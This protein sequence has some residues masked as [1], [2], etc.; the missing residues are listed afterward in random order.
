MKKQVKEYEVIKKHKQYFAVAKR[1]GA[2]KRNRTGIIGH[3]KRTQQPCSHSR[4]ARFFV[5]ADD[6]IC[7]AVEPRF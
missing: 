4:R 2:K 1:V 7:Y 3:K 6:L 5:G